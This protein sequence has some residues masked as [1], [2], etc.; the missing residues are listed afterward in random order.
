ME[1][2]LTTLRDRFKLALLPSVVLG[3]ITNVYVGAIIIY[4]GIPL[5]L[6]SPLVGTLIFIAV[7]FA[8]KRSMMPSK[9]GFFIGVITIMIEVCIHSIAFGWNT[10]FYFY[11]FL[12]PLVFLL[13]SNWKIWTIIFFNVSI[14]G[15]IFALN[16]FLSDSP[17]PELLSQNDLGFLAY[18]NGFVTCLIA[19]SVIIYG[20]RTS[21]KRDQ[22]LFKIISDL[23]TSNNQ[24]A[25]QH[26]H[27]KI[28][29]KEIH[30]RVKNNL[31]I[32][33]SL[34]S[35]QTRMLDDDHVI[36]VLNESRNRVEAIAL[37]HKKLYQDEQGGNSVD[38]NSY[39]EDFIVK[40]KMLNPKI[41]FILNAEALILHLDIA[42]PLGL[43]VSELITNSVKHAFK[44]VEEPQ[45]S[46]E[47]IQLGNKFEL[48]VRD[49]GVGLP[50]GFD[51]NTEGLGLGAD[52]I[53]ALSEQIDSELQYYNINGASCKIV[54]QNKALE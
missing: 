6:L 17:N 32:I 38:F 47:L 37:I 22:L 44:D 12:L 25:Q 35:L 20:S 2:H 45:V 39:L 21:Y 13:E 11:L 31:Q 52:I 50:N 42:V 40:E 15:T 23:E 7:Y 8:L 16:F 5:L 53:V 28:L 18:S 49:N 48:W 1:Q 33:S 41:N 36:G 19:V 26:D 46:L 10:G 43:I 34:L 54:F 29:L 9:L 4:A 51:I 30:H 27:Q 24:I 14:F 3:V